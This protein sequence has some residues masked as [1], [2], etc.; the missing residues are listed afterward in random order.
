MSGV[1]AH[2]LRGMLGE[3][4]PLSSSLES[5]DGSEKGLNGPLHGDQPTRMGLGLEPKPSALTSANG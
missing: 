2:V 3:R 4:M 5:K 1:L